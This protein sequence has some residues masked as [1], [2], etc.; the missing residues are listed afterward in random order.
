MILSYKIA[1]KLKHP[2]LFPWKQ[3]NKNTES[4]KI[5]S[6]SINNNCSNTASVSEPGKPHSPWQAAEACAAVYK[7]EWDEEKGVRV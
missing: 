7:P 3:N 5:N 4:N 1:S 6:T 2:H